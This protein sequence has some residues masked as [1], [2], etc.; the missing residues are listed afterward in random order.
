VDGGWWNLL[1]FMMIVACFGFM[2]MI[3]I[4]EVFEWRCFLVFYV[5]SNGD[6]VIMA[7]KFCDV[8]VYGYG[9]MIVN[10]SDGYGGFMV[11]IVRG[12][13]KVKDID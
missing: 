6:D 7:M 13:V 11:L 2:M 4:H 10:E 1:R 12:F 3:M 5:T 8:V 9:V